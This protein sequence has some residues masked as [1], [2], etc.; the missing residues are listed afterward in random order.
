[1]F[2]K[3][4]GVLL[5]KTKLANGGLVLK[6]Y[7]E[8]FGVKSFIG[9]SSKKAKNTF[10][11]LSIASF[12]AY[13]NPKNQLN[14]IKDYETEYALREIYQDIYKSNILIFL[15]EILNHVIQEEEK[16]TNKFNFLIKSILELETQPLSMDFHLIFLMQFTSYLGLDPDMES[17]GSYFDFAEG[18][19]KSSIPTHVHFFDE[20]E[21]LL[22]KHLHELA[23]EDGVLT[24]FTNQ[25]RKRALQL[26]VTYYRYHTDMREL[27]SL[28]VL[29]TVFG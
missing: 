29:E 15:N 1:M 5:K 16:N 11:P 6:F 9:R 21:T 3:T 22:F 26:I 7:T 19:I 4:R 23:F 2:Q 12:S 28:P 14:N 17:K 13:A 10:L 24:Q 18:Q 25:S 27:K 8:E 20:S